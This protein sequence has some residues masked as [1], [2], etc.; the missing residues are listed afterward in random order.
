MRGRGALALGLAVLSAGCTTQSV[1]L[2][3]GEPGHP[4]GAVAVLNEDGSERGLL[5]S[6]NSRAGLAG[7]RVRPT[8]V[9]DRKVERRYGS[10]VGD[11]PP[12]AEHFI[13]GFDIGKSQPAAD[14]EATLQAILHVAAARPG[15]EVQVV[16]HTDTLATDAVNDDLSMRRA[17]D[18]RLFLISRGLSPDQVRATWR[19]KR[20]LK[21]PT[22]DGVANAENRRV[23]VIVR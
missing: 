19:G 2:L 20:E 8:T 10:L 6:A 12:P 18:V 5:D 14:Q 13:L 17:S 15:A 9:A 7:R 23:E 22:P 4:V 11:L 3:P 1:T 16:G 21:V